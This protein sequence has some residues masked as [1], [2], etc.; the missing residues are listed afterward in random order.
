MGEPIV[1]FEVMAK[2][3]KRAQQF[4]GS[5]FKWN[6]DANNPMKYGLI[7]TGSKKG[8]QGG[9]GKA[10]SKTRPYTTFYIEVANPQAYLDRAARL[11]GRVIMPVTEIPNMVTYAQFADPEGNIIGL[12]KRAQAAPK[13]T[14]RPSAKAKT[15]KSRTR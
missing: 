5:L 7:N 6:I 14:T 9:I 1:H 3:A 13:R 15:S 8:I 10:D 12:V 2:N 11:G 4:Y